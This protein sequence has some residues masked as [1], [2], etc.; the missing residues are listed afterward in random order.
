MEPARLVHGG[1]SGSA[2]GWDLQATTLTCRCNSSKQFV[3]CF[4][5][6]PLGEVSQ[7]HPYLRVGL[8][9]SHSFML[10]M[11]RFRQSSYIL[12]VELGGH[13]GVVWFARD[14]KGC[15][16]LGMHDIPVND[17]AHLLFSCPATAVVRR[18]R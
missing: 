11:A 15:A 1:S 8:R 10:S 4:R 14:C 5:S 17:E 2:L 16:A 3:Q 13:Q 9:I 7:P 18:E 6:A 12:G